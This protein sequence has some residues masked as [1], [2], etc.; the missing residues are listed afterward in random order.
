MIEESIDP[1]TLHKNPLL[2]F[3]HF[4][5][6]FNQN[7]PFKTVFLSIDQIFVSE[8]NKL[9]ELLTPPYILVQSFFEL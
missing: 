1:H 4:L 3:N 2:H 5:P 6:H 7:L 8:N 9:I